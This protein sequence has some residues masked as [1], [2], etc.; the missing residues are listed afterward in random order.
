MVLVELRGFNSLLRRSIFVSFH[1]Y[2]ETACG[3]ISHAPT[4]VTCFLC[5]DERDV[6]FNAEVLPLDKFITDLESLPLLLPLLFPLADDALLTVGFS[7]R[8]SFIRTGFP[9]VI[10]SSF[11]L[12]FFISISSACG[13]TWTSS[14]TLSYVSPGTSVKVYLHDGN[15][16][17]CGHVCVFKAYPNVLVAYLVW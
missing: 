1:S 5:R 12:I 9:S 11:R 4:F 7:S 13:P 2:F 16:E 10:S 3:N 15:P 17:M 6:V 14:S 8:W